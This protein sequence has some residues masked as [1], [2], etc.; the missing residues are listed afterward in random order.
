MSENESTR[1]NGKTLEHFADLAGMT[2]DELSCLIEAYKDGRVKITKIMAT[3]CEY[4][5]KPLTATN[6]GHR[7]C[8]PKCKV[9]AWRK[10]KALQEGK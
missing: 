2:A 1:R 3:E 5:H 7:F 10:H 8:S 4:C 6:R 9:Y